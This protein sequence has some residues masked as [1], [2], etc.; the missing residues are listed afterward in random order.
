MGVKLVRPEIEFVGFLDDDVVLVP[1]ALEAVMKY[2]EQAPADVGG[3]ALNMKNH[4][5]LGMARLKHSVL[6]E[7]WGIY[8]LR[9]GA[10]LLSGFQTAIGFVEEDLYVDWLPTG[11]S[12]W[13]RRFL[14]AG[15]FDEWFAGYSYLEDLDFS[16]RAG[17]ICKLAVI[18]SA[19]YLHIPSSGGRGNHFVFG[20]REVLARIYFVKKNEDLS[21]FQCYRALFLRMAISVFI[22][23][24]RKNPGFLMRAFGNMVGML[25]TYL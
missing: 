10:V 11:A 3:A 16:Y 20:R 5:P 2:W 14:E 7:R 15:G 8:T 6:A 13:R 21:V 4:P 1:D 9:R 19:H 25:Q 12:I 23:L 24:F 17:K 18:H 22:A